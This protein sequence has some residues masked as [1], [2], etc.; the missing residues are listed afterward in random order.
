MARLFDSVPPGERLEILSPTAILATG[1]VGHFPEFPGRDECVGVSLFWCLH[2]DGYL[3]IDHVVGVVGHDEEGVELALCLLEFTDHV[4]L[5]AG[6]PEG[7][8]VPPGRL[9]DLEAN[10]IPA[11]ACAV[12]R[13]RCENGQMK[14]LV[15]DDAAQTV[16]P[17]EQVYTVCR[18]TP[19]NAIARE[20]GVALHANGHI[21]VDT[22]Q[23]TNVPGVYAA[24]DV[25]SLHNHQVTAAVHEGNE[26]A[27]SANYYLYKPFQ[28]DPNDTDIR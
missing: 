26:A 15:L 2:C 17:V 16:L 18:S 4:T 12:G 9:A 19:N 11:H 10:G 23:H 14:A 27:A 22:T 1:V 5:V 13:Y 6:R 20:L 3:S 24:G 25:T 21:L 8:D 7:F 28:R